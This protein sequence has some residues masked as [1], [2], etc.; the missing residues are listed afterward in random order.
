MS[1]N[2]WF[3]SG[4]NFLNKIY[5]CDGIVDTAQS[6]K[7]NIT[8]ILSSMNGQL[9]YSAGKFHIH[10]YKYIAPQNAQIN[11]DMIIGSI[12]LVT[13]QTRKTSYNRVKGQFVSKETTIS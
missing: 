1:D 7:N 3:S 6:Y 12:D 8:A 5:R 9:S 2:D 4:Q 10:A 13:K 11:E